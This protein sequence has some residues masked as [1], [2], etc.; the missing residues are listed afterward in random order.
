MWIQQILE[1]VKHSNLKK[2]HRFV[3][4]TVKKPLKLEKHSYLII[5]ISKISDDSHFAITATALCLLSDT[6]QWFWSEKT[7]LWDQ[8]WQMQPVQIMEAAVKVTSGRGQIFLREI[9]PPSLF[10]CFYSNSSD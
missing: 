2:T 1:Q 6:S 7:E 3:T 5:R 8:F 4:F 9:F 10:F